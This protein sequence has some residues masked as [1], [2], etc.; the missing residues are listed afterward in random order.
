MNIWRTCRYMSSLLRA[1]GDLHGGLERVIPSNM[2]AW[3]DF[4]A[5]GDW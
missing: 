5:T 4:K 3:A 2:A 1:L